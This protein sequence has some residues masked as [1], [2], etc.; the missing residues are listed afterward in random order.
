MHFTQTLTNFGRRPVCVIVT[1][2]ACVVLVSLS[3]VTAHA[4]KPPPGA[5]VLFSGNKKDITANW[6]EQGTT[7]PA[8]WLFVAS[9]KAMQTTSYA[10]MPT[11]GIVSKQKFQDCLV[12]VEFLIPVGAPGQGNS[13]VGLQNLYE[14]QILESS[15]V[16]TP[17]VDDCGAVYGETSPLFNACLK[18]GAWQK[19]DIIFRAPRFDTLGNKIDDARMT[20]DQNG[21]VIQNNQDVFG[22]TGIGGTTESAQ[23]GPITLQYHGSNVLFRN[24][25]VFPLP[26][27]GA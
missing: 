4:Q 2:A 8:G 5:T 13:G 27:P 15:G 14:I 19:Y 16:T 3:A 18:P 25:W 26:S 11:S 24:V 6:V 10:G 12:H 22:P 23:P 7:K 20:V 9:E 17:T 21:V 1:L